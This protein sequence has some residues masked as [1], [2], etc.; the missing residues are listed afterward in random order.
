MFSPSATQTQRIARFEGSMFT[1]EAGQRQQYGI[2]QNQNQK[3]GHFKRGKKG[4][5][6][7]EL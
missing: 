4:D 2:L 7:K 6:L 1:H 3:R 5:I